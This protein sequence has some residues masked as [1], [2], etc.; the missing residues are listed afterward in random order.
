MTSQSPDIVS[1]VERPE[2]PIAADSG[3]SGPIVGLSQ[4]GTMIALAAVLIVALA[5]R[6]Y[7]LN[8]D[9]G[10]SWTPHPD[11]RAILMNVGELDFPSLGQLGLLAEADESPWNPRW[12]PYGSFPLY[13]LKFVQSI[14]SFALG[15]QIDDLRTYG[16]A[17]SALADVA[18]IALVYLL[19][20]ATSSRRIGLIAAGL[21]TLAV[22]HIQLSHFF[23]VD[24]LL[25]LSA[26]ATAY[27]LVRV[28]RDGRVTDSALAGVFIGLGLA[29]KI[30]IAPILAAYLVAHV[31]F[32]SGMTLSRD[33]RSSDVFGRV[34]QTLTGVVVGSAVILA[35]FLIAQPYALL[36]WTRFYADFVEQSEMVRRIRDYPYTRQYVDTT[37]Y[38]YHIS[39]SITWGLGWPLGIA[40]WAGLIFV[41]VRG[42]RVVGICAYLTT[43]IAVPLLILLSSDSVVGIVAASAVAVG[44]LV[45]TMPTRRPDTRLD[46]MLLTWIVPYFLIIGAFDVKFLRYLLPIM[47]FL[48]LFGSKMMVSAW[49]ETHRFTGMIGRVSRAVLV[50]LFVVT[51]GATIFYALS[52]TGVY[53][54]EHPAVR[55]SNWIKENLPE[56]SLILKE[57]W[58]EG[59]PDLHRYRI[60]E[61]QMYNP[62]VPAKFDQ[63]S[64]D[65]ASGDA[66]VLYSNRLYGT[67]PRLPERYPVSTE[68][69]RLLFTG[70]LGYE[71][72]A[73]FTAFPNLFGLAL[74]DDTFG[75]PDLP[76]PTGSARFD[77]AA[78]S[79]D[80]GYADESFTVYDHPRVM[81]FGN[82]GRLD[83]DTIRQRIAGTAAEFPGPIMTRV[84][85]PA[86]VGRQLMLTPAELEVRE[87]G[88]TWTDIVDDEGWA[89]KIPVA[90]W[91]I[92]VEGIAILAFPIGFVVFRPL[93]DRGWLL[94]KAAGLLLVGLVTWL[95]ASLELMAFTR[96]SVSVAIAAL[97][98]VS[99]SVLLGNRK[100]ITTFVRRHWKM[101]ALAEVVFLLAFFAFLMIRAA[102]P[103][104]WHPWR[105]GE[106]PMDM[107][108]LHAVLKSTYMPP[109]DPWFGG[110]YINYYY[111]GQF[112]IAMLIHA[113]GIVPEIAVNIA[114]PT[115]F[116]LTAALA[117][118]IAFNM[119]AAAKV[120]DYAG[121]NISPVIAGFA[122]ALF[123]A[124][125]GN[126]DGAV[127]VAQAAWRSVVQGLPAGEFDF[128]KS[129]RMMPPD[130]PGHEIT[131]FPF[132]T[133]LFAD[134]H[135]HLMALPFTLLCVGIALAVVLGMSGPRSLRTVWSLEN[136]LRITVLGLAIGALRLLNTWDFPTYLLLGFAAIGLGEYL[137]LGG[138]S[139]GMLFRSGIKAVIVFSVGYVAFLPYHLSYETFFNGIESTTNTT[140]LWQF[141]AIHGL[142]VFVIGTFLVRELRVH[143]IGVLTA[144][145]R[146]YRAVRQAVIGEDGAERVAGRVH[147]GPALVVAVVSG[148]TLVGFLITA[149]FS[150]FAWSAALFT[151]ALFVMTAVVGLRTLIQRTNDA[152]ITAFATLVAGTAFALIV[153]LEFVRVEG[154]IDRMNSVFKFYLQV[155][156]LLAICAAYMVWRIAVSPGVSSDRRARTLRRVWLAALAVLIT[157]AA[158]FPALGTRD[159]LRDRFDG[160]V[161]PFTLN[162]VAYVEGASYRYTTG[163][164]DLEADFEGIRWLREN[165][166]GS[167]V[168][169]E[170]NTE[171]YNWGGRVSIYTGLPSVV[172]WEWHQ[173]QQR[174]EYRNQVPRR[175]RDVDRIYSTANAIEARALL[176]KYN[177]KYVYVGQLERLFYPEAGISKFDNGLDGGLRLVYSTD[178]VSIYEVAN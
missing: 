136:L 53:R 24:T 11:E 127:Q 66:L 97:F 60:S 133:F 148:L 145:L 122:G 18:T 6:F 83:A 156:V 152:P 44:S 116:A 175:I 75:R 70:Q 42:M 98:L 149:L 135:A 155:W 27:F 147:V 74:V 47:P 87:A 85:E 111:W 105:G 67:L 10:F 8:W 138:F 154:D 153:G 73:Q 146:A 26:V 164:V 49:S 41:A 22:L 25:T 17:V 23:A 150:G 16:R 119:A 71:L 52:Y 91:L 141:L 139:F 62:D 40:A 36:D 4:R 96:A 69:Y 76:A 95:L 124:V 32:V 54:S 143:L 165:V 151:G 81:I 118:S 50:V 35:V 78:A 163:Q 121:R 3:D 2:A 94:S 157:C 34:S 125:L 176:E 173:Q 79:L 168:I 57:H 9:A 7:G 63:V 160:N 12:F 102:N 158:A 38:L 161:T 80:L 82:V 162:G 144:V 140:T 123:V 64:A 137:A 167:P 37:P 90:A 19:G 130:P 132:F 14:S 48:I 170:A 107:A 77:T 33:R 112:L 89:S 45:A 128:W 55:A 126:L 65:L 109:Y 46:A 99:L 93:A 5:L 117:F 120:R 108:Y 20:A 88:G 131:E 15:A 103:D 29:T 86:E 169:L 129:S 21:V 171:T 115:F 51:A 177:V 84:G 101:I 1:Q 100:A 56:R 106:K 142:F 31:V 134:P 110:G 59:L 58:E 61:L 30:S 113:T 39:Q 178:I 114:V 174:W 68:Y 172:G 104:L 43:G 72:E 159:R 28:A 92:V 13:L 166:E